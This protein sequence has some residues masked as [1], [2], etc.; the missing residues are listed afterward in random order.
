[1]NGEDGQFGE[2]GRKQIV[3]SAGANPANGRSINSVPLVYQPGS[4]GFAAAGG[5]RPGVDA[6]FFGAE[7]NESQAGSPG[8]SLSGLSRHS[9]KPRKR[10]RLFARFTITRR[11]R[12]AYYPP[13]AG[14][15]R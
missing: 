13:L 1:L 8:F 5:N 3:A 4:P 10:G 7:W 15:A 9:E 12:R 2:P 14:K 11:K 6:G